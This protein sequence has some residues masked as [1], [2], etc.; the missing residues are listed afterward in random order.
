MRV[1]RVVTG[2]D[3]SGKSVAIVDD[4]AANATSRRHGHDSRLIWTTDGETPPNRG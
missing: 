3:E 2:H 1:R 4:I